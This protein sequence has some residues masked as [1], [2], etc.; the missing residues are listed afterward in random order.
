MISKPTSLLATIQE[1][2]RWGV[3]QYH[4]AGT[5]AGL[6]EQSLRQDLVRRAI[7]LHDYSIPTRTTWQ[8]VPKIPVVDQLLAQRLRG[9]PGVTYFSI[10][11][12]L[13][14]DTG[15]VTTVD[16]QSRRYLTT[17]DYG[18]LTNAGAGYLAQK[19]AQQTD[20]PDIK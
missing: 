11:D 9:L 6:A 14:D 5:G 3:K 1:I 18:H 4:R 16:G 20:Y 15:C 17:F 13:C 19:L 10:Y 7:Y 8:L 2:R 12:A